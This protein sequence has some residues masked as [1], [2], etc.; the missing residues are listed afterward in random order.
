MENKINF[1]FSTSGW[2][3]YSHTSGYYNLCQFFSTDIEP[4]VFHIKLRIDCRILTD[5]Y[6]FMFG[7][8]Y[9]FSY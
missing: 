1:K 4:S 6:A 3:H 7:C 5:L 9:L 8:P 2:Y